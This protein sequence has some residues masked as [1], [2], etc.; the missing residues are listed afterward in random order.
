MNRTSKRIGAL[1]TATIAV[2]G[3]GIAT[4]AWTTTG[5]DTGTAA[6]GSPTA[7]T[8]TVNDVTGVYPTEKTTVKVDV[9]NTNPY[10]VALST[11]TLD[12]VVPT[13]D[14]CAAGD[15]ALDTSATGVAGD[16]KTYTVTGTLT[17]QDGSVTTDSTSF[18]VPIAVANL[19]DECQG[20][21]HSFALTFT[22]NGASA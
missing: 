18:N 15:I 20:A 2:M 19:D 16:A 11:I 22:V 17:P 7:M 6:A 5:T 13:G 10:S 14:G 21:D 9:D 8:V 12:S 4:A 3:V 1:G